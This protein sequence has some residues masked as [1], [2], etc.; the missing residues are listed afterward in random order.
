[1]R[2][3]RRLLLAIMEQGLL[4]DPAGG[5]LAMRGHP[6]F[7]RRHVPRLLDT[8]LAFS[9]LI[10]PIVEEILPVRVLLDPPVVSPDAVFRSY[11]THSITIHQQMCIYILPLVDWRHM[12]IIGLV[13][14]FKFFFF[15][16]KAVTPLVATVENSVFVFSDCWRMNV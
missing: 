10:V 13:F 6:V 8:F 1:M 5:F 4:A 14:F 15:K 11:S 9:V 2:H 3:T 12:Q 7:G 16:K